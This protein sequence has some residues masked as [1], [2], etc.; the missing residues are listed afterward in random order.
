MA[1]KD[2]CEEYRLKELQESMDRCTDRCDITEM[3]LK[4]ALNTIQS[5]N[6]LFSVMLVDCT[7]SV[8]CPSFL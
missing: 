5:V 4:T 3:L 1:W 8:V 6:H 2:Y 7:V